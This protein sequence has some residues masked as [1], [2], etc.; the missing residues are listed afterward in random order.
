MNLLRDKHPDY[1]NQLVEEGV[2]DGPKVQ[3][4]TSP[5]PAPP[6]GPPS[7]AQMLAKAL[8]K[9]SIKHRRKG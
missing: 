4:W 8:A 7:R 1:Y 2:L 3:V 6:S 9:A 5:N